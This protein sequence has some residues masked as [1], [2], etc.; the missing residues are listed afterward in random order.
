[1]SRKRRSSR[2]SP[3]PVLPEIERLHF[4]LCHFC[5]FLNESP[6][7][8]VKCERCARYLT[9]EEDGKKGRGYS[10]QESEPF[11][12]SDSPETRAAVAVRRRNQAIT[13]LSVDW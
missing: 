5:H 3:T 13:G 4:R 9:G 8:I 2:P 11:E 7:D 10:L 6:S 12:D 1:M